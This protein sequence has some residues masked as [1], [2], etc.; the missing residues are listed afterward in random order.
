MFSNIYCILL[1]CD[2]H[3]TTANRDINKVES[4]A[5]QEIVLLEFLA[6]SLT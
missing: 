1:L 2:D 5:V 3:N 4:L 6:L